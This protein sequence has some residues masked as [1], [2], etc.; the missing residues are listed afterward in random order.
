MPKSAKYLRALLIVLAVLLGNNT[1]SRLAVVSQFGTNPGIPLDLGRAALAIIGSCHLLA[2]VGAFFG[3]GRRVSRF[4][5]LTWLLPVLAGINITTALVVI[6]EDRVG[7]GLVLDVYFVNGLLQ[8][9]LIGL[10][11]KRS[12]RTYFGIARP[13]AA[14]K[15]A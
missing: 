5:W 8:L 4:W 11:L 12:V 10:L 7:V 13:A 1:L 3:L 6:P 14:A 9:L 15:A 2:A